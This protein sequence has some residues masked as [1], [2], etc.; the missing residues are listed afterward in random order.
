MISIIA[1]I[2]KNR[3][4]GKDGKLLWHIPEDMKRFKKLTSGHVVIMGRKTFESIGKPLPNRINII[5]TRDIDSFQQKSEIRSPK[6]EANSNLQNSN[7]QNS[8]EFRNSCFEF[9]KNFIVCL[10]LDCAIRKAKTLEDNEIFVIG[11]GQIYGQAM[12]YADKLYLTVVDAEDSEADT[13]FPDYSEFKKII[14]QEKIISQGLT[15]VFMELKK[16]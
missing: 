11:G 7:D 14:Y 10:S 8:F 6:S 13:F 1:A 9:N 15:I 12:K 16:K 3:E 2:G 4:L 5:I